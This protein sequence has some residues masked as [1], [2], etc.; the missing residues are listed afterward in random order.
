MVT[1]RTPRV[2]RVV[3]IAT[4]PLDRAPHH[5]QVAEAGAGAGVVW[6][7]ATAA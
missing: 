2:R 7:D 5:D 6:E 3:R 1:S 4:G